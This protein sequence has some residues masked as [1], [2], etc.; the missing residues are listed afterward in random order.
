MPTNDAPFIIESN[1]ELPSGPG[2]MRLR[3]PNILRGGGCE[4]SQ[5]NAIYE[6]PELH[7]R[8]CQQLVQWGI[9]GPRAR[10]GGIRTEILFDDGGVLKIYHRGRKANESEVQ[11]GVLGTGKGL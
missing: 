10:P 4:D 6:V 8:H 11:S 7:H 2:W 9:L 5:K 1:E 3:A